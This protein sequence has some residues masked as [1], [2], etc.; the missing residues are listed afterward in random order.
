MGST[1]IFVFETCKEFLELKSDSHV[2]TH[3]SDRQLNAFWL[4]DVSCIPRCLESPM[5]S[6]IASSS[7]YVG[8]Y[9]A[10]SSSLLL[11]Y[12][13]KAPLWPSDLKEELSFGSKIVIEILI[14]N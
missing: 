12:T 2:E 3:I 7:V 13:L 4:R 14:S 11:I 6:Y 5:P 1:F 10:E 9:E 8:L